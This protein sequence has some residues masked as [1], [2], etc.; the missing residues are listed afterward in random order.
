MTAWKNRQ[1]ARPHEDQEQR[2]YRGERCHREPQELMEYCKKRRRQGV[3][4]LPNERMQRC[5]QQQG[6]D[7]QM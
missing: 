2:E 7:A 5:H 4:P 3:E 1:R 6:Q